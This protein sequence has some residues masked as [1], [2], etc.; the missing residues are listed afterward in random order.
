MGSADSSYKPLSASYTGEGDKAGE[1]AM[2]GGERLWSPWET[3]RME[4]TKNQ[5]P[6]WTQS[7]KSH[8]IMC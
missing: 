5:A 4:A 6:A 3:G 1:T 8:T 7:W 2:G